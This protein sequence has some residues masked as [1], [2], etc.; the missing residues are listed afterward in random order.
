MGDPVTTTLLM[1]GGAGGAGAYGAIQQGRGEKAAA[2]L[3]ASFLEA[4]ARDALDRGVFEAATR[5]RATRRLLGGQ[6]AAMAA[7]GLDLSFGSASDIQGET[8]TIGALDALMIKTN[9]ARE[10]WGLQSQAAMTRYEGKLKLR[11]SKWQAFNTLL[12]GG[13]DA[14][15][16]AALAGAGG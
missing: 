14:A 9:A 3:Q 4:Q 1:Q 8:E 6:R 11:A 2:E 13:A 5:R 10:A 7:Q 15:K 16:T 12:A